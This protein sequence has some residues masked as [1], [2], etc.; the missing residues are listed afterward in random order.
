VTL[1]RRCAALFTSIAVA[2][3]SLVV[4][5]TDDRPDASI[6]ELLSL[7]CAYKLPLPPDS[8]K[9]V[10]CESGWRSVDKLGNETSLDYLGFLLK[11]ATSD[12]PAVLLVGTRTFTLQSPKSKITPVEP[13]PAFA[14]DPKIKEKQDM[15]GLNSN[16]ALALQCKSR[17]WD[18]LARALLENGRAR[19]ARPHPLG[20]GALLSLRAS[21]AHMAWK[22]W[23][24]S[25]VDPDTDRAEIAERM[26]ALLVAEPSFTDWDRPVLAALEATLKPSNAKPGT[27]E[28]MIDDLVN[29]SNIYGDSRPADPRILK[30]EQL[31]FEAVPALIEHWDD[32]RL[33]RGAS[34]QVMNSRGYLIG[35]CDA[36]RVL[37]RSLAG[38]GLR[39]NKS[40][41]EKDDVLAWWAEA[42]QSGEEAYLVAHVLPADPQAISPAI[43]MLK[44]I[45]RKYPRHLSDIY[46]TILE[47][48]PHI[49]TFDVA[50]AI[51][52]SSLPRDT[53]RELFLRGAAN[54]N[55]E[56][57]FF[58]LWRLKDLDP[59]RFAAVLIGDLESLLMTP[60]EPAGKRRAASLASLV[61]WTDDPRAWSTLEKVA[62]RADVGLRMEFM[63][64]MNYT[65]IADR[66]R[67]QRLEFLSHFLDDETVR[68]LKSNPKLFEGL[69]AGMYFPKIEVRNFAAWKI[70][71]ILKMGIEPDKDWTPD[72]WAEL[73]A[74]VRPAL[75]RELLQ[76]P[77]KA[78]R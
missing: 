45:S 78:V 47:K 19:I 30:L 15:F 52:R 39:T 65:F 7:Y 73:R 23:E 44:I 55:R 35:V 64:E 31:G 50:E 34:P 48:R 18:D 49:Q 6:D 76:P 62:K 51:D 8:A 24:N 41:F 16:L 13:N 40:Q 3:G 60:S 43:A 61:M 68:D 53:K 2:L 14:K 21:V 9:L 36:V 27:I 20:M 54:P 72:H 37:I 25:L 63:D 67:R 58:A 33:S 38:D 42:R 29:V 57:R 28:A 10:R 71:L 22:H 32:P 17:G 59:Q 69:F 5:A 77:E 1:L 26:T 12:H 56:H 74:G 75:A 46:L 70:G 11:P 4:G 66:Q